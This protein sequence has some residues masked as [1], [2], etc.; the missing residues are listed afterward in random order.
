MLC[1]KP[2]RSTIDLLTVARD[3]D[4][5][6]HDETTVF[7]LPSRENPMKNNAAIAIFP[8]LLLLLVSSAACQN[9]LG[10][11]GKDLPVVSAKSPSESQAMLEVQEGFRMDLVAS[12]PLVHDP[13]AVAF[14][15]DGKM[16]VVELPPYNSYVV[17]DFA[18]KGSIRVL[19]DSDDD[20]IYD[21]SVLFASD[22]TYPT[23]IAC[24]DGG[25]FVG[26]APDLLYLK[27]TTGDGK[28][29]LRTVVF[30][31]F[32]QDKAGEA[33]LN[34][35]RWGIDNRFHLSTNLSGGNVR[36]VEQAEAD[37][38]AVSVRGRG[39]I[40][41]PMELGKFELTSG[42]GQHGLS[43]D[44]WGRKFV[45]SNSVPAQTLMYDDR[46][47]A[48]N[49]HL[50]APAAAVDIAPEGK[51][52][53]LFR[54]SPGEPWRILRTRLRKEGKFQGSDEGGTPFGFFT[55]ATGITIYRGD[56]WP[57]EYR[58]NLLV[59]DVANNLIYRAKL[60]PNGLELIA[61]RADANAEFVASRDMSFR[62]VQFENA[63]D[64]SLYVLDMYR[65][66][67]EGAAFLPPEFFKHIDPVAGY[68]LGRI[69]RIVPNDFKRRPRPMLS[70]ATTPELVGQL[71]HANGWHRDTASRLLR[72]REDVAA[73]PLLKTLVR[74]GQ[75]PEGRMTA[76]YALAGCHSM[77]EATLLAALSDADAD[78]RSQAA[79]LAVNYTTQF[80]AARDHLFHMANDDD[81]KVRYQVAFSLG[82]LDGPLQAETIAGLVIR[83]GVDRW[84]RLALLSSTLT[85]AGDVFLRLATNEDSR[86]KT[87]VTEFLT[88]LAQQIGRAGQP[89]QIASILKAINQIPKTE[90]GLKSAIVKA[91][92]EKLAGKTREEFL[93][94]ASGDAAMVLKELLSGARQRA[95][96]SKLPIDERIDAI[97]DLQLA[98]WTDVSALLAELLNPRQPPTV[99]SAVIATLGGFDTPAAAGLL[100]EHWSGLSPT[101]RS[102]A[103]EVLLS[104]RMWVNQLLDA[105]ED[106][107]I[108]RADL[109]PA[110]IT[111]LNQHP[112]AEIRGRVAEVFAGSGLQRRQTV[113]DA[114]QS[115]L[116]LDGN[117]ERGRTIFRK[118]CTACHQ[119]EGEGKVIGADLKG[120]RQRGLAS[121]L[122]NVLDPNREVKPTFVSYVLLTEGG[123]VYSGMIFSE[124]ANSVTIQQPDGNQVTIQR[125]EIETLKSTALSFMPEGLEKQID[126]QAMADLLEYLN[127]VT[128]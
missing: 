91:T 38:T 53:K 93:S 66:L 123:R 120:I 75:T 49:P 35:I 17:E 72:Q 118:N 34:S 39:L 96:D 114:Y 86:G 79:K 124:N 3:P 99:R 89:R 104:R 1:L 26:D 62:P 48:R 18:T 55:G 33:H 44:N 30:T 51:Y 90:A 25:V 45:C 7:E 95:V 88:S 54:I 78:V 21:K 22:L 111:L 20:G 128:E 117:V 36:A 127:T 73:S 101:L 32:G 8:G 15:E 65:Q 109:D 87:H 58:G 24:W 41:D 121:I 97:R 82:E 77:D 126:Q 29:D 14:D 57:K 63:P 85:T 59:G 46:Y 105:V 28:A 81:L 70:K 125:N 68:T 106:K 84:M 103:A 47:V 60:E 4:S 6:F 80:T 12:E 61:H 27:D 83:D 40:F 37:A 56:A 23:A 69:Y 50:E 112:D 19:N 42:G 71:D 2:A 9:D 100:I 43:M 116:K 5:P 11:I 64:G 94:A 107:T 16:Y 52:T 74:N 67:I 108:N 76:F 102:Q 10:D 122:L 98:P 92:V 115:A 119:L 31:G 110:R 113:V 13:V